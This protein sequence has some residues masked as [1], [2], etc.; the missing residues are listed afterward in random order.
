MQRACPSHVPCGSVSISRGG[1][2]TM[3]GG[4]SPFVVFGG[5]ARTTQPLMPDACINL[6]GLFL[7]GIRNSISLF[8]SS[9]SH[10]LPVFSAAVLFE[11]KKSFLSICQAEEEQTS[12]RSRFE[13]L[14][15]A[16]R[17]A[18]L[19]LTRTHSSLCRYNSFLCDAPCYAPAILSSVHSR[20]WTR[21]HSAPS[22]RKLELLI[23]LQTIQS[24]RVFTSRPRMSQSPFDD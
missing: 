16:L 1:G 10:P 20:N 5:R 9:S 8:H 6:S 13:S 3:T 17:G 24:N 4:V 22:L 2:G 11:N 15:S 7:C 19:I 12:E 14:Y 18:W 21:H 23:S